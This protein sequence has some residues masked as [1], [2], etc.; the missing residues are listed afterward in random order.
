MARHATEARTHQLVQ[1][2]VS[3][4]DSASDDD[5]GSGDVASSEKRRALASHLA[6][7]LSRNASDA[8]AKHAA[9]VLPLAFVGRFDDAESVAK[10]WQEVWEENAGGASSTLRLYLDEILAA[11]ASRLGYDADEVKAA[12]D[13]LMEAAPLMVG[14]HVVV[15]DDSMVRA[16]AS[17]NNSS[18]PFA[19]F[20]PFL[21]DACQDAKCR[22]VSGR[23][24]GTRPAPRVRSKRI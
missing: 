19:V 8:V 5:S 18:P 1:D 17:R 7:E 24:G 21:S 12:S 11:C 15:P 20:F 16:L 4:Y 10:R 22:G 2:V 9:S 23:L 3:M 14:K 13:I 6:L